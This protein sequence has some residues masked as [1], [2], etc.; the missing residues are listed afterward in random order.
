MKNVFRI[1]SLGFIRASTDHV[2]SPTNEHVA[3]AFKKPAAPRD[4]R[5]REQM[6]QRS[7][8]GPAPHRPTPT[9]APIAQ[10]MEDAIKKHRS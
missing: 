7:P 1:F 10:T 6:S 8:I 3:D 9:P 2:P 5:V 4:E